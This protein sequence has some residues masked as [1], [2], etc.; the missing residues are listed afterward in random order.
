MEMQ[1]LQLGFSPLIKDLFHLFVL[2]EEDFLTQL[3]FFISHKSY[4]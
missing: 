3:F 1:D 4:S 2:K